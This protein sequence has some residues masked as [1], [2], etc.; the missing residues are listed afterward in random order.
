MVRSSFFNFYLLNIIFKQAYTLY[1]VLTVPGVVTGLTLT[2]VSA[3]TLN[4]SWGQPD[5]T[6]G[7]LLSYT[8]VVRTRNGTIFLTSVAADSQLSI[9]VNNLSEFQ[10]MPCLIKI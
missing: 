4:V 9:F 10:I 1:C 8:V 5:I 6:N 3:S 2:S 7:L